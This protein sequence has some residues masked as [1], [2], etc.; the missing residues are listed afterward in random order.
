MRQEEAAR[1]KQGNY[2]TELYQRGVLALLNKL[3]L[4]ICVLFLTI[5]LLIVKKLLTLVRSLDYR[6]IGRESPC[7]KCCI[8]VH[9]I[10]EKNQERVKHEYRISRN[11]KYREL[12]TYKHEIAVKLQ[13]KQK[14]DI[15]KGVIIL[16]RDIVVKRKK[17]EKKLQVQLKAKKKQEQNGISDQDSKKQAL[18]DLSSKRLL[19][20]L[21]KNAQSTSELSIAIT[22]SPYDLFVQRLT[23]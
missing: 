11:Q 3:I 12:R 19:L 4:S 9:R 5:L 14:D 23:P 2:K 22:S 8:E 15:V 10:Y 6:N 7:S 17:R 13:H 18:K 20:I 21:I 1:T 16:W